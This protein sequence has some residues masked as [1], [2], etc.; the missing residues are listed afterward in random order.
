VVCFSF[1]IVSSAVLCR[2]L[3][4]SHRNRSLRV[5]DMKYFYHSGLAF[6]RLSYLPGT[7]CLFKGK[8]LKMWFSEH[9]IWLHSSERHNLLR[10]VAVFLGGCLRKLH[11]QWCVVYLRPWRETSIDQCKQVP[12][13]LSSMRKEYSWCCELWRSGFGGGTIGYSVFST[14]WVAAQ[15]AA[16]FLTFRIMSTPSNFTRALRI[17]MRAICA[18][19]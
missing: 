11:R 2:P 15:C 10:L 16:P 9:L 5:V 7:L 19:G 18:T 3:W 4:V 1:T 14:G 13:R 8:L 12:T 6:K 17:N